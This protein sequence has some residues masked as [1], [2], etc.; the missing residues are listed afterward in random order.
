LRVRG[1]VVA[2]VASG[3]G[4]GLQRMLIIGRPGGS[5]GFPAADDELPCAEALVWVQGAFRSVG[6]GSD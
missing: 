1:F 3:S 4:Q 6:P 5:C 2:E